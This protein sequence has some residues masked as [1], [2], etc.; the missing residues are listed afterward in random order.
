MFEENIF[1][2][3]LNATKAIPIAMVVIT[4]PNA[5][6]KLNGTTPDNISLDFLIAQ[7]ATTI[8]AP[9]DIAF[10]IVIPS[11]N[12][13]TLLTAYNTI[14]NVTAVKI[15]VNPCITDIGVILL[16]NQD[17]RTIPPAT[18]PIIIPKTAPFV[19]KVITELDIFILETA[20]VTAYKAIPRAID[21]NVTL[22]IVLKSNVAA[23]FNI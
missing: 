21:V 11:E 6:V 16:N 15:A 4:R 22:N 10:I 19:K 20:V 8:K 5:N 7:A 13:A 23:C 12:S 1:Q 17:A 18:A 3:K 14:P 2:A 9:I